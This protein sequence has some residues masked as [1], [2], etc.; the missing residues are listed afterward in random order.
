MTF[1]SSNPMS[2]VHFIILYVPVTLWVCVYVCVGE[3]LDSIYTSGSP[4]DRKSHPISRQMSNVHLKS[5]TLYL[6]AFL[7]IVPFHSH[8]LDDKQVH[9]A[10]TPPPRQVQVVGPV[11]PRWPRLWRNLSMYRCDAILYCVCEFASVCALFFLF[12]FWVDFDSASLTTT[13]T[14]KI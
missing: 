1:P 11:R 12:V 14:T 4:S 5:I 7:A 3:T 10:R 13:T 6:V 9:E 2:M 8:L